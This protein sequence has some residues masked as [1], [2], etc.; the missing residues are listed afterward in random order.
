MQ[1]FDISGVFGPPGTYTLTLDGQDPFFDCT[2]LV[3]AIVNLEAGSAPV[4]VTPS[5]WGK[6]KA[7]YR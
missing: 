7:A 4:A 6:L 1:T 3:L 2:G 5:S